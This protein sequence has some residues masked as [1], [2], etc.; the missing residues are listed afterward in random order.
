MKRIL[1]SSI[2]ALCAIVAYA[3]VDAIEKQLFE[4]P[5]LIFKP[6]DTPKGFEAAYELHIKQPID[7]D[8]PEMGHFYQRA[9]LS[10]R[11]FEA[12]MVLAT[13][14]Y[15]RPSNRMY[16]LTNYLDANQVDVEHRY[17]GTSSPDSLD[18]RFLNLKQVAGDLHR[19][20]TLLGRIYGQPWV[21]TGISK[22]GQTTIF[23]RYFYPDDVAASVPYVAPLNLE[24]TDDRIY[25]FL[26]T[27]GSDACRKAIREVQF[28]LLRKRDEVLPLLR[29]HAK[30]AG[31]AFSYMSIEKAF[32]YAVLEYP[33]S[34]WQLGHDC[35][36]IPEED[37]TTDALLEHFVDVVG[38]AF[39]SDA[40]MEA[41]GSHYY[42]AGDEM[43]YYGFQTAPF[44]NLLKEIKEEEPT[45]IFMPG[46]AKMNFE[47][48]F[49][50][51]VYE[52]T[53]RGADKM[54]YIYGAIDTWTATGV[55]VSKKVDAHWYIMPG[56]DHGSARIKN[57]SEE[58][59]EELLSQ[60][61]A[62]IE[63]AKQ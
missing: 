51:E 48:G 35:E 18:Y 34:F 27:V 25:A 22:G 9:Y 1:F 3:Q 41:Y 19:I 44:N 13:E 56:E 43:G 26:D 30:G 36:S 20:R 53:Q 47:P 15:S 63:E 12:P 16:E 31:L 17:F 62:W 14:G 61:K 2:L 29:W 54:I 10:H 60:L 33:F 39:Y 49:V 32:E 57:L 28:R 59:R 37:A 42:Q 46:K 24:L 55:P 8:N 50:K 45:A 21:T 38:L 7:H 58:Q 11:S 40:S 4:L 23:Y 6:I 52:W 5:D